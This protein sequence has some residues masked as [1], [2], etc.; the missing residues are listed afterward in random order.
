M[1][2]RIRGQGRQ[3]GPNVEK[4]EEAGRER[5]G[6]RAEEVVKVSERDVYKRQSLFCFV[7]QLIMV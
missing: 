2:K 1:T 5:G 7:K 3:S 6:D 4:E